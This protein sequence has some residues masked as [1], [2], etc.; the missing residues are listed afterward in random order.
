MNK[1]SQT[2]EYKGTPVKIENNKVFLRAFGTTAYNQ[3]IHWSWQEIPEEKMKTEF[4]D[5]L[6]VNNLI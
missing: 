1:I 4:K 3:S 2:V 6:K 5:F